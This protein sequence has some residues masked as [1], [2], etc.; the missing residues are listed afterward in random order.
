MQ[1]VWVNKLADLKS[2]NLGKQDKI[3]KK[4]NLI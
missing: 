4:F 3:V 2:T 1:K